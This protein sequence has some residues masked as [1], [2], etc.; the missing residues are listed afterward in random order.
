MHYKYLGVHCI[1]GDIVNVKEIT[2]NQTIAIDKDMLC[3]IVHLLICRN[4]T[5]VRRIDIGILMRSN[6]LYTILHTC[7]QSKSF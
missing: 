3:S 2:G 5:E 4:Q 1:T 6:L 7:A